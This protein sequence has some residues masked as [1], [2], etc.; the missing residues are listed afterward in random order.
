MDGLNAFELLVPVASIV[1]FPE[2]CANIA[3][4]DCGLILFICVYSWL[5]SGPGRWLDVSDCNAG[6]W[7]D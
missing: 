6:R 5:S 4:I 2:R 1:L 3:L 7:M